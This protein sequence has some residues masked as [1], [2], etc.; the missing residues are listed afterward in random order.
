MASN[1]D[2]GTIHQLK[3]S[4]TGQVCQIEA[5]IAGNS[6]AAA[7]AAAA[8]FAVNVVAAGTCE[9]VSAL[10]DTWILDSMTVGDVFTQ[11][12]FITC[13]CAALC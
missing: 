3:A 7:A 11:T 10:T 12:K 13:L 5:V 9:E 2:S 8:A 4:A 6:A 1:P